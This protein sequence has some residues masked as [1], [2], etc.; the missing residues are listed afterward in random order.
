MP[1]S[2]FRPEVEWY[3]CVY[4][5]AAAACAAGLGLHRLPRRRAAALAAAL[6][7][8][9]LLILGGSNPVSRALWTRLTPLRYVRY[10]GNLAYLALL[11]LAALVGA[12]FAR[13]ARAPALAALMAAELLVCGWRSTPTSPRGLFVEKGPLVRALQPRL[14]GTR[15]LISPRALEASSGVS[16]VDWKTRLYGLTNAP[17]RLRAAANFGEPLVPA[18]NYEMMD[19]VL[20]ARSV[21]EAAGWMPWAGATRL[22]TPAPPSAPELAFE[23]RALWN[24]SRVRAPAALAY[25]LSAEAGAALPAEPPSSPPPLAG[26]PLREERVREDRFAVSGA[27]AGWAY[28]AEPRYPGWRAELITPGGAAPADVEPALGVFQKARVPDGPWT[29]AFRYDPASW[30]AGAL[31]SL[32]ALLALG[33]YWYH[34]AS[35]HV[36]R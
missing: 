17:Y 4:L 12:G 1:L 22:L 8:V 7:V 28:V 30:R 26:E 32:A 16:L 33:S 24:V 21:S 35:R 19:R 2:S 5:G 11:P 13:A 29:L 31:L 27:G 15:Y 36:A 20:S 14:E 34:R 10:P 25:R 23:D 6:A 9:V 18:P 3:K